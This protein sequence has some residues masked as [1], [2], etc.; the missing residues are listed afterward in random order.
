MKKT[1]AILAA[2]LF[3][4]SFAASAFAIHAE[5]PADTQ[6]IVAKGGT[7]ITLGG[8]IRTRGWWRNQLYSSLGQEPANSGSSYSWYDQRVRLLI[9]AQVSPN[10]SGR[11]HLES[12]GSNYDNTNDKYTWG[13]SFGNSGFG[14]AKPKSDL[15]FLEAWLQYKGSGLFGFPAGV[16]VGHMPLKLGYGQFFDHTQ[17]GDDALVFFMDPTKQLHIGLLTA[18]LAENAAFNPTTGVITLGTSVTDNTDDLDA[19]VGLLTYKI[20]DKNTIG[21]NYTYLNH[22][23]LGFSQQNAGIH[24]D[25]TIGNFGYRAAF[26]IQFGKILKGTDDEAKFKGWQAMLAANYKMDPVNLRGMFVYGS[27]DDDATDDDIEEFVPYMGN[28]QNYAF[29]YEYQH[30]TSALNQ[31]GLNPAAPSNGHAAGYANSMVANLGIDWMATKAVTLSLDGYYIWAAET[32]GWED[33]IGEDVSSTAG[34]EI[35]AKVKYAVAKNL[36]YQFDIGYFDPGG[37]F[38]DTNPAA[39]VKG[40]TVMRHLLTLSF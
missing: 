22:S 21:L 18:K 4:L 6:A 2:A 38:E 29:I 9:D 17:M 30:K 10:V 8:E 15:L 14:N 40:A 27:G 7:Q 3:V 37:F 13:T 19:Y 20:N 1:F 25:G 16:K 11:I 39:D 12:S 23:D 32:G 28:I 5:I 24:A 34:W 33:V 35:D 26:D 31:S 36:T